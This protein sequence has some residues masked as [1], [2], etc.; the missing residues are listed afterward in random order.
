[1]NAQKCI[2]ALL[3]FAAT[4]ALGGEGTTVTVDC[5]KGNTLAKALGSSAPKPLVLLIRGTCSESVRIES[6]DVTLRPDAGFAAV[7]SGPDPAVDTLTVTGA[8]V[9]LEGIEIT[10][11]RNG[12]GALGASGLTVRN[13]EVRAVGRTGI[14]LSGSSATIDGASVLSSGRDGMAVD[15]GQATI[16]NSTISGST[17]NGIVVAA[18]GGARIGVTALNEAAGNTISENTLSGIVVATASAFIAMN[19][20]SGNGGVGVSLSIG[21]AD[22]GGGN[23]ISDNAGGGIGLR[24]ASAIVGNPAFDFST[25]NTIE[26]NGGFGGV[27]AFL[28][29]SLAMRDAVVRDNFG[30][31]IV[32][33]TRS[34][35]QLSSSTIQGNRTVGNNQG[36][37][38]RMFVGSTLH[39]TPVAGAPFPIIS[40]NEGWGVHCF[41]SASIVITSAASIFGNAV[42]DVS[43]CFA[44]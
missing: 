3:L 29:S 28:D 8:R 20:I 37:G 15:G 11:G 23:L 4:A 43:G 19:R 30:A 25:V 36:D 24:M 9:T 33:A 12:V 16:V 2:P 39:V 38:V 6:D 41:D 14:F 42:G 22:L 35:L 13:A 10:G 44:F 26:R 34:N 7:I 40:G 1:M 18:G 5:A 27:N 31:G 21:N 32:L 17:R